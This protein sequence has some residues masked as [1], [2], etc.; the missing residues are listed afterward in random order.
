MIS[1]KMKIF[2]SSKIIA[3]LKAPLL[4]NDKENEVAV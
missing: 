2:V 4:N 3:S 1:L